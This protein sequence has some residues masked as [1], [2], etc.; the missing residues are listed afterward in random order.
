MLLTQIYH[1]LLHFIDSIFYDNRSINLFLLLVFAIYHLPN[2]K[3]NSQFMGLSALYFEIEYKTKHT[4]IL[5]NDIAKAI[6]EKRR[7]L[8]PLILGGIITS[9]SLLSIFLYSSGLEVIALAAFGLLLTYYGLQEYTVLH[10]EYS[11][12]SLLIWLPGKAS[13]TSVRPFVAMLE[14]Y[15][16]KQ[17]FPILFARCSS[18]IDSRMV[19]HEITPQAAK[20]TIMYRFAPGQANDYQTVAV[21]PLFL[22]TPLDIYGEGPIIGTGDFLINKEALVENNTVSYS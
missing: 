2:R 17:H 15:L 4:K 20:A 11:N 10:I 22:D 21:N 19:H 8:A 9:L 18:T 12:S 3:G 16:N 1:K 14:Y 13:L 6:L 7:K 5:L